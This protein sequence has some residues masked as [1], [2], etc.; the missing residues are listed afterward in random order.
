MRKRQKR[1][2]EEIIELLAEAHSTVKNAIESKRWKESMEL[3]VQCQKGA[4]GLGN[5]IESTEGEGMAVIK[6]LEDYCELV[7]QMYEA[8]AQGCFLNAEK[9]YRSLSELFETV[10]NSVR[11][12]IRVCIE[13]VFLP[14]KASMWDSLESVWKAANEDPDC[15]AYVIPIPYYDK[16]PDGSFREMH[17]EGDKYPD[18][19]PVTDYND[20]DFANRKPDMIFIHNPYDEWNYVTSV[21]PFFFSQNLKRYTEKLVYIPYY[22]LNEVDP[23][24]REAVKNVQH[25]CI[26]PGVLHADKVIVQSEQMRQV[27]IKV[28]SEI[29]GEETRQ[30]WE[31]KILGLGSPKL[32]KAVNTGKKDVGMPEEWMKIIQKPDGSWKK[33]ILYNTSVT[34]LLKHEDKMLKKMRDVFRTFKKSREEVSLLWR[35]HPLIKAT[36][37]SMRP[38]LWGKYEILVREYRTEGWGIYDETADMDRALVISDAYYGDGS[39]LVQ[40]CRKMGKPVMIQNVEIIN[41]ENME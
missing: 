14:Y 5:L 21:H 28:L 11:N 15:N 30:K 9:I 2:A 7:Y 13:A 31:Q 25:F 8:I 24:D 4:I 39:S 1:Q 22:I 10:E 32:D 19:V 6:Q 17:Y 40:L 3:L 26:V 12:E 37:K 38:E 36:I 23:K 33:I 20:Y 34:A 41:D 35:P 29:M 27:Y 18:Y 16:N